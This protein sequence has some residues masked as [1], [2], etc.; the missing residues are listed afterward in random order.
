[1][2]AACFV[3]GAPL[4][5]P[6]SGPLTEVAMASKNDVRVG[7]LTFRHSRVRRRRRG[8]LARDEDGVRT[9]SM[10]RNQGQSLVGALPEL[11]P[12]AEQRVSTWATAWE[13]AA[14]LAP[15]PPIPLMDLV[16]AK[17]DDPEA[18]SPKLGPFETTFGAWVY[19]KG[20]RQL[21]RMLGYPGPDAEATLAA[22][23]LSNTKG[24]ADDSA[25]ILD[26]SCGPG[27]V[28][29]RLAE[30]ID[31]FDTLI[32]SDVSEAMVRRTADQINTLVLDRRAAGMS[33]A[34]VRADVGELP[35]AS[36]SLA[37]VHSSAGAHCW[38]DAAKGFGEVAR[39]LRP[40]GT[41]VMSTVVLAGP[42]KEK[43]GEMGKARDARE[44]D[45]NVREM[46][47]PFWD[48]AAVAGMLE[49][50][51]FVEVEVVKEDKCFV[52]LSARKP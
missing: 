30:A 4:T 35:F 24:R 8:A 18:S 36:A 40:K 26:L 22:E 3:P 21:F 51:G 7:P 23:V 29:T 50:A 2:S 37:A 28:T 34:A 38:P 39:V 17:G 52:M 25:K 15:N 6:R 11:L 16:P 32:A 48:S 12:W 13:K 33:F 20:Y 46:N 10:S 9:A 49:D 45:E 1:M 14:A 19:D 27:L 31:G 44:Y 5:A 43:Y 47:T 42:M 41:F